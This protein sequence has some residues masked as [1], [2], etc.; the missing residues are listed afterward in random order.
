M[1]K[2]TI[3]K[4]LKTFRQGEDLTINQLSEKIGVSAAY[5]SKLEHDKSSPTYSMLEK[6]ANYFNVKVSDLAF[7][8]EE[9]DDVQMKIKQFLSS[10]LR[11]E[12]CVYLIL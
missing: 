1:S 7:W 8:A 3:G 4:V 11:K 12:Y 6:Y 10:M 2:L 9:G 5:I